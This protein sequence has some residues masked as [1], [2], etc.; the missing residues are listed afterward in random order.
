MQPHRPGLRNAAV[1]KA[2]DPEEAAEA[3]RLAA[4]ALSCATKIDFLGQASRRPAP[5]LTTDNDSNET[6][7]ESPFCTMPVLLEFEDRNVRQHFDRTMR[8]KCGVR[9]SMSLPASI[10]NVQ[11]ALHANLK[12]AYPD[13][14]PQ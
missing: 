2:K 13:M 11:K 4:D 12:A 6:L 3:V 9:P 7:V 10:R 8:E 1:E 14:I 5:K